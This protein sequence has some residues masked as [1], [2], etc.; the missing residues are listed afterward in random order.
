MALYDIPIHTLQGDDTSLGDYA[1]KTLLLVNV[2]S[3]CGLTPQY[4]GLER[5]QKTYGDRGFSVIGF[6]C[7]QFM[8]QEPGTSEEI[9]EFCSATYGV[10]FPLME[11]IE[12]N[13]DDRHPIYAEL[14]EKEDAEGKAG[15]ITWNFEKFL[16]SP[17][18][19]GRGAL[20]A[21]GGA[22]GPRHRGRHRGAAV[23][24]LIPPHPVPAGFAASIFDMDGLLIDSEILWHE[25]EIEILGGLGVP[26]AAEGCRSTKGMF[27]RRG[28]RALVRAATRGPGPTPAEVAV[29]IVDRVIELIL[30]KGALK[31]GAEHAIDLC[32]EPR[33]RRWPWRRR[34]ST[35][36]STPRW[37]T[38]ACGTGS[39][40]CTRP[41]TRP[42]AS[43]IPPSS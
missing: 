11:K 36:S 29:T 22:G 33:P 30:T 1:G 40:W 9:A 27:V 20:P 18:G 31:P 16:V 13:G 19:A 15:D 3:K 12:V 2:A 28:D 17:D 23:R 26:L 43:R 35:A 24:R 8:G 4:E 32:A 25:A 34:R 37:R 39:R 41:R 5:L 10:T 42:T 38:S 6:P 7:N 21:P 14:T